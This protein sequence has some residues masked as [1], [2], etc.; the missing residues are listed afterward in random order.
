MVL[1]GPIVCASEGQKAFY[2]GRED[3]SNLKKLYL[4]AFGSVGK[5]FILILLKDYL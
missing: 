2:E 3:G 1:K 5:I 4:I